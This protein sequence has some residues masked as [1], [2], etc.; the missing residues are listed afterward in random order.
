MIFCGTL[1]DI[2][3]APGAEVEIAVKK[4][5]ADSQKSLADKRASK[6][7]KPDA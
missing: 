6:G 2:A 5:V 4:Q 3:K 1:G 7:Q